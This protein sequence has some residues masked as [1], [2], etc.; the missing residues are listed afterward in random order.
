MTG[1]PEAV[2]ARELD[3]PYAALNVVVNHAA[4]RSASAGGI[5]FDDIEAMLQSAMVRVRTILDKLC[6]V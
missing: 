2:L 6:H 3:I 5:V 4:G 1:M